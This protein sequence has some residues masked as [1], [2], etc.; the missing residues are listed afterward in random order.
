MKAAYE[1]ASGNLEERMLA[2]L[3]AAQK[4]GGDIRGKQ[5]AAMLVVHKEATGKVWVDR[6]TDIRIE[7]HPE[8]IKE[9]RRIYNVKKAYDHMNAG[10]LAMEDKDMDLALEEYA[11]AFE[12]YP[13]N[14]EV[15][16]WTAV[17]FVNAGKI[18]ESLFL[19]KEVFIINDQ[20]KEVLR[21]IHGT[22]LFPVSSEMLEKILEQ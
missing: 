14:P 11:K 13:D 7:D 1:S 21:R 12:L 17:T 8:P 6:K 16:F 2:S 5:S 20:W 9:L 10:D 4:V 3:E 22:D 19:F 18:E 15:K